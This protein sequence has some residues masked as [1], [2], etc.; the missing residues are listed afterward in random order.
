MFYI[1]C[2]A[3]SSRIPFDL[4]EAE[5]E[6]VSGYMTEHASV[7]FVLLFLGEYASLLLFA[8]IN[9]ILWLGTSNIYSLA[10]GMSG[11]LV[12]VILL[13]ALLPRMRYDQ[14]IVFC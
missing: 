9:S 7:A 11:F 5:S 4:V 13:R 10:L 12:L 8:N 14:L 1:S 3:E 6:L 2:L